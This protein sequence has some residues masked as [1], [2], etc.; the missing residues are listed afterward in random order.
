MAGWCPADPE[1]DSLRDGAGSGSGSFSLG[2]GLGGGSSFFTTAAAG[3]YRSGFSSTCHQ[4]TPDQ[5]H[6]FA[7]APDRFESFYSFIDFV[8]VVEIRILQHRVSGGTHTCQ[9]HTS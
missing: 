5:L 1:A 4:K 8:V 3:V 2:G 7:V 6:C 9:E